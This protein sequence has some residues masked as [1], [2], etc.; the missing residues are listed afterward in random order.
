[1]N[2]KSVETLNLFN[3]VYVGQRKRELMTEI[4]YHSDFMFST[5]IS[6]ATLETL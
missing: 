3:S 1:M 5:L 6:T 2:E 4:H